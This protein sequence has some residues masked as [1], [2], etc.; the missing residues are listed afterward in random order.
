MN[1]KF[2]EGIDDLALTTNGLLLADAASMRDGEAAAVTLIGGLGGSAAGVMLGGGLTE[3]EAVATASGQNKLLCFGGISEGFGYGGTCSPNPNG[4]IGSMVLD[5]ADGDVDGSHAGV[6]TNDSTM[7]GQKLAEV[8]RLSFSYAGSAPTAGSPRL[9]LPLD[10]NGDGYFNQWVF[11]PARGCND[12]AGLVDAINDRTCAIQLDGGAGY[13]NWAALVA[14]FP[15]AR[16]TPNQYVLGLVFVVAD[17][18]GNR[19]IDQVKLG[20]PTD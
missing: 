19:T 6:Y 8:K 11:I 15:A 14:A 12:G 2:F 9:S 18:P 1:I 4:T 13:E 5:T 3:G 7:Y 17:E 16:I 10:K 20:R